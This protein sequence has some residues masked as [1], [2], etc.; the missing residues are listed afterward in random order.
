[1]YA[2]HYCYCKKCLCQTLL[3]YTFS[4][5]RFENNQTT[6]QLNNFIWTNRK[7][8]TKLYLLPIGSINLLNCLVVWLFLKSAPCSYNIW[9]FDIW[10]YFCIYI[11]PYEYIYFFV[12]AYHLLQSLLIW[13]PWLYSLL[14][15]MQGHCF[16]SMQLK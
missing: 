5:S 13:S 7:V 15:Y 10:T 11:Y 1:M 2:K 9:H 3:F 8:E 4:G 14:L 16:S 6:N 12:V